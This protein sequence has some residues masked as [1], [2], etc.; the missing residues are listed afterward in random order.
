MQIARWSRHL[1]TPLQER[2]YCP[3]FCPQIQRMKWQNVSAVGNLTLC[4]EFESISLQ[5]RVSS[6]L[7]S[8]TSA[9]EASA[10]PGTLPLTTPVA[11]TQ[12]PWRSKLAPDHQGRL[13]LP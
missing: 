10:E 3:R 13:W 11:L 6:K 9:M 12:V 4:R 5:R 2:A 7:G 1:S 8:D